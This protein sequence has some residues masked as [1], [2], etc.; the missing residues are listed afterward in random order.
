VYDK[1]LILGGSE[2]VDPIIRNSSS[3]NGTVSHNKKDQMHDLK[4]IY[5]CESKYMSNWLIQGSEKPTFYNSN[6][7]KVL[8]TDPKTCLPVSTKEY[9][10]TQAGDDTASQTEVNKYKDQVSKINSRIVWER[11]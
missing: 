4:L 11:V 9:N 8:L 10:L 6:Q 2:K 7:T 5:R 1:N 3:L